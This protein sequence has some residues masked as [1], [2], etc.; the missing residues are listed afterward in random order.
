MIRDTELPAG[1]TTAQPW[2]TDTTPD[3]SWR[4]ARLFEY[5]NSGPGAGVNSNRPQLTDAQAGDSTVDKYLAGTDG[6]NPLG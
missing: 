4:H 1:I 5:H 2:T 6:W 3:Y